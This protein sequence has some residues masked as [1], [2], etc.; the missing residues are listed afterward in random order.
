MTVNAPLAKRRR[1]SFGDQGTDPYAV[2]GA[3]VHPLVRNINVSALEEELPDESHY[4]STMD[5]KPPFA[6]ERKY[7]VSFEVYLRG[8]TPAEIGLLLEYAL[9]EKLA[10]GTLTLDGGGANDETQVTKTVGSDPFGNVIEVTG[11]DGKLYYPM[12]IL[13]VGQTAT[14][15]P[16]LPAGVT[17]TAIRNAS[18]TSGG[19]G[20]NLLAT[21]ATKYIAIE[22]DEAGQTNEERVRGRGCVCTELTLLYDTKGL[23]GFGFK[24]QG[25]DYLEAAELGATVC[26]D[27]TNMDDPFL[28]FRSDV[29]V[30]ALSPAA[31]EAPIKQTSMKWSVAPRQYPGEANT[32]VS[33]ATPPRSSLAGFVR[34]EPLMSPIEVTRLQ[35]DSALDL[36]FDNTT[37]Y[38]YRGVFRNGLAGVSGSVRAIVAA[39]PGTRLQGRPQRVAGGALRNQALKLAFEQANLAGSLRRPF[40]LHLFGT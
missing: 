38:A 8:S 29:T 30:Q 6:G 17:P 11:D 23:L 37:K 35:P 3:W 19:A 13:V 16:Q 27:P 24:F 22:T 1:L 5:P 32:G 15:S 4:G 31:E 40:C 34:G 18:Q 26:Q 12:L 33:G 10:M 7:E 21:A 25:V 2:P 36:K 39:A 14:L 9:G 28:G 20:Y